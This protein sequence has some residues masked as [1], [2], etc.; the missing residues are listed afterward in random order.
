MTNY[1]TIG[2][3]SPQQELV[4]VLIERRTILESQVEFE[5]FLAYSEEWLKLARDFGDLGCAASSATCLR[6]ARHYESLA[7]K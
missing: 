4:R 6:R 2:I 5:S 3:E 1:N 7:K